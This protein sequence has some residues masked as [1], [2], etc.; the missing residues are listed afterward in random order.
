M[1]SFKSFPRYGRPS[2]NATRRRM[3]PNTILQ[4]DFSGKENSEF[5]SGN[6]YI[7]IATLFRSF[8]LN[9]PV[10][11]VLIGNKSVTAVYNSSS[12]TFDFDFSHLAVRKSGVYLIKFDVFKG[13]YSRDDSCSHIQRYK[14]VHSIISPEILITSV[15][16]R[17]YSWKA[18]LLYEQD[19]NKREVGVFPKNN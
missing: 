9:N 1:L 13:E 14:G 16:T 8:D 3:S 19:G 4:L 17:H 10:D 18:S 12:K 2:G 15:A 11:D 7:A 5:H 6:Y